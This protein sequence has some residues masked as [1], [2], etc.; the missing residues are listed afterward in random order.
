[1]GPL[2][3]EP[4]LLVQYVFEGLNNFKLIQWHN[5]RQLNIGECPFH[6]PEL[7]IFPYM[8]SSFDNPMAGLQVNILCSGF[9]RSS[10]QMHR[11]LVFKCTA[12]KRSLTMQILLY[13][14]PSVAL[15]R[16][17]LTLKVSSVA[18]CMWHLIVKYLS[19]SVQSK[20]KVV[21]VHAMKVYMGNGSI[22]PHILNPGARQ[23]WAV[24]FTSNVIFI[25]FL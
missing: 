15:I 11:S 19:I 13:Y 24:S 2:S 6:V 25:I 23:R 7:N 3:G 17:G 8:M 4:F 20:G 22:T 9:S 14:K 1:V 21:P 18:H 5:I 12:P 10:V 16:F